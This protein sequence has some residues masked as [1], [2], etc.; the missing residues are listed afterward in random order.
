VN[1][2][3][4]PDDYPG[5]RGLD[6]QPEATELVSIGATPDGREVQL[7]PEAAKAWA[8]MRDSARKS[9][10][11]ILVL[12]GFRSVERQRALIEAKLS[13]GQDIGE[14]LKTV[15]APGFSEHHTGRALDVAVPEHPTLTEAFADTPAF[16]WLNR[17][18]GAFGF[19]LS[20][21]KDN[22]HG[23]VYEPWHWLFKG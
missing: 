6:P 18:A 23:F 2:L 17:N 9:G 20:Y 1:S 21:P 10:I 22:P 8:R 14:I 7:S 19:S 13:T 15:A 4:I 16:N 11:E 5:T 3:G 12:S